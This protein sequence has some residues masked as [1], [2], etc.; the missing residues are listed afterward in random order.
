MDRNGIWPCKLQNHVDKKSPNWG[1]FCIFEVGIYLQFLEKIARRAGDVNSARS[2]A[3]TILHALDDAGGFGALGTVGALVGIHNLLTV[4]GF[5][6]LR[7][8]ASSPWY[9]YC[10]SRAGCLDGLLPFSGKQNRIILNF[11]KDCPGLATA[12]IG[13]RRT[14][15]EALL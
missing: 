15:I 7:H 11:S 12:G 9:K 3:L 10:G 5:G 14:A 1:S 8:N 6:N 2:A 13:W 4:A